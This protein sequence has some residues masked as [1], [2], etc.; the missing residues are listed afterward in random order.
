MFAVL[1]FQL[2]SANLIKLFIN[3]INLQTG[4]DQTDSP[5]IRSSVCSPHYPVKSDSV[6]G[7]D[8]PAVTEPGANVSRTLRPV[9]GVSSGGFRPEL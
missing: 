9:R 3:L 2:S 8:Q 5:T 1:E 4:S 6:A 7:G